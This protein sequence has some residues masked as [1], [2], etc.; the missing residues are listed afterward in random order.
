[1]PAPS[2]KLVHLE[3]THA[4]EEKAFASRRKLAGAGAGATAG[5]IDT[6][7]RISAQLK[8]VFAT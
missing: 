2:E 5:F 6:F 3:R 4:L 1:M 8:N 7:F